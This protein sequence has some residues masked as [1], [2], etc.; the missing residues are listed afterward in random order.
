M[1][2]PLDLVGHSTETAFHSN[3]L[4]IEHVEPISRSDIWFDDG[5]IVLQAENVQ[6]RFFQG[7]LAAYSPFFKDVFSIPQPAAG[8]DVVEGCPVMRLPEKAADV[9]YM[10][11]FILE[12]KS[13]KLTPSVADIVAAL[14]M[15]HKYLIAILWDDA[16][17]RLRYEFPERLDEYQERRDKSTVYTRIRFD[18]DCPG[19]PLHLVDAVKDAGLERILPALCHR[20]VEKS[21]LDTL[22]HGPTSVARLEDPSLQTRIMLL[23]ARAKRP[24]IRARLMRRAY[25]EPRTVPS[26]CL[27]PQRCQDI[28]RSKLI[29]CLQRIE[30]DAK[31]VLFRPWP[32][33]G[34]TKQKRPLCWLCVHEMQEK[35]AAEQ[36]AIWDELPSLFGLPSWAELKDHVLE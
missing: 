27:S 1:D 4:A 20:V 14:K 25:S 7:I 11:S 26:E 19:R 24:S 22:M 18:K 17:E 28:R 2:A 15:G 5:N 32:T 6:F 13:S 33:D 16:V 10:L 12:S 3:E 31:S 23:G 34:Q 9:N 36:Q 35:L 21:T 29:R 30:E 8:A